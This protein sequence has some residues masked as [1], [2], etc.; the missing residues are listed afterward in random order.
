MKTMKALTLFLM[1]PVLQSCTE[2]VKGNLEDL[3]KTSSSTTTTSLKSF[4][5]EVAD[6]SVFSYRIHEAQTPENSAT[7]INPSD[8]CELTTT[9][10]FDADNPASMDCFV[11]VEEFDLFYRGLTFGISADQEACE[12]IEVEPYRF[13]AFEP[14]ETVSHLDTDVYL[15]TIT[16]YPDLTPEARFTA[17]N[18][19]LAANTEIAFTCD[20]DCDGSVD[21]GNALCDTTLIVGSPPTSCQYDHSLRDDLRIGFTGPNCDTGAI[22]TYTIELTGT[23]CEVASETAIEADESSCGG[24]IK[25]CLA[26]PGLT[27]IEAEGI[28]PA[29]NDS[30]V[31][32]STDGNGDLATSLT[33]QA[34]FDSDYISNASIA[35]YTRLCSGD[36]TIVDNTVLANYDNATDYDFDDLIALSNQTGFQESDYSSATAN[37]TKATHMFDGIVR[38]NPYYTFRC[39]D[40]AFDV[41]ATIRVAVREWDRSYTDFNNFDAFAIISDISG[42]LYGTSNDPLMDANNDFDS[43]LYGFQYNTIADLDDL[44]GPAPASNPLTPGAGSYLDLNR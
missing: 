5:V 23:T 30:V 16:S 37:Y 25:N 18:S 8:P 20:T 13:F 35:N 43:A 3:S 10:E 42:D 39:L 36:A 11:E 40:K 34:P 7:P 14:G 21:P 27:Y 2:E 44:I 22:R 32:F 41:R 29:L 1:I 17:V 12:V 24:E 38:T 31:N 15:T 4:K 19:A 26:G 6:S 33:I 9:T 28:N